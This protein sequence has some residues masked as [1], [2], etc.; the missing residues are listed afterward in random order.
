MCHPPAVLG[1]LVPCLVHLSKSSFTQ[2]LQDIIVL[3]KSRTTK[4]SPRW[5]LQT[6]VTSHNDSYSRFST[7]GPVGFQSL[8]LGETRWHHCSLSKRIFTVDGP[9]LDLF[10]VF[11]VLYLKW[12][13]GK[14]SAPAI[15]HC[16]STPLLGVPPFKPC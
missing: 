13:V 14:F 11:P 6:H 7:A 3:A 4:A 1:L 8:N 2:P 10:T 15:F 16:A 12:Y 5:N 9:R